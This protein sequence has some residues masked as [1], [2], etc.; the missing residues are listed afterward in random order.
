MIERARRLAIIQPLPGIGDMIWHLPHIRALTR[1]FGV[2]ATVITKPR[3]AADQF[4]TQDDG[5]ADIMWL[6]RNP[7]GRKGRHDG[8]LGF[9]RFALELRARAF[10]TVVLLHHSHTLA[11][12][13]MAAGIRDRYGYGYG[14][15]RFF[16]NHPARL[17]ADLLALHQFQR[18]TLFLRDAGIPLADPEPRL[19]IQPQARAAALARLGL[20]SHGFIAMGIGSSETSRQWGAERFA[21]LSG[22]LLD[23]GWEHIVLVGGTAEADMA[24]DIRQRLGTRA[25]RIVPAIGWGLAEVAALC[26]EAAFYVGN[27]TGAMNIAAAAGTRTYSLFGDVPPFHHAASIVPIVTPPGAVRGMAGI[28][29]GAVLDAVRGDRGGL[30][31]T[32]R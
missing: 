32:G 14:L 28:T 31:P 6:D 5:V 7:E 2:S 1:H 11:F 23:A 26:A 29:L 16:L 20:N 15:Q 17:P 30:A 24:R 27:N 9:L 3:S 8:P 4:L 10:D 19:A 25:D 18:A 13:T 21:D 22:S 12:L